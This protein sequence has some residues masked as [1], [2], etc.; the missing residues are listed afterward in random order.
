MTGVQTCA[1]PISWCLKKEGSLLGILSPAAFLVEIG[2]VIISQQIITNKQQEVFRNAI[3]ELG[4]VEDA[5]RKLFNADT[6]E[7]SATIFEHWRFEAGLVDT[8][9]NCQNPDNA[10][11]KDKK[12]AQILNVVRTLVP[13][14]SIITNESTAQAKDLIIKYNLDMESFDKA[15][16]NI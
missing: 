7:V 3:E 9:R 11:E 15:L 2:K 14:N 1:L 6:P 10:E 8:I 4:N 12:A 5:E 16:E 13:L